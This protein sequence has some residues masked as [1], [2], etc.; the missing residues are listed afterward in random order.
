M[1]PIKSLVTILLLCLTNSFK[2]A[3]TISPEKIDWDTHFKAAPDINSN[4]A[5]VTSTIWQYGYNA[6]MTGRKLSIDFKFLAGIDPN[7]SWVNKSKIRNRNASEALLN[8]EQGHV[9]INFLQ[10]KNGEILIKNQ[11][12]TIGNFKQ[13]VATKAKEITRFYNNLQ[14]QYDIETKHGADL[15]AQQLWDAY[16][17]NELSKFD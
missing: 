15:N 10:L 9:Y 2:T 1:I 6:T 8:H 17:E 12:Y 16:F 7:K 3:T 5:A 13:L 4:Y 14:K 11:A